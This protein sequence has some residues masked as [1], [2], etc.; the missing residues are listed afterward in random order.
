MLN[1]AFTTLLSGI[2]STLVLIF[3]MDYFRQLVDYKWVA[4]GIHFVVMALMVIVDHLLLRFETIITKVIACIVCVLENLISIELTHG[5]TNGIF[6]V[7]FTHLDPLFCLIVLFKVDDIFRS[8]FVNF[9]KMCTWRQSGKEEFYNLPN[10]NGRSV[11]P[12]SIEYVH[13]HLQ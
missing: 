12:G 5:P 6:A 4:V 3:F 9:F 11:V 7:A 10:D 8:S 1:V 2:I 13:T